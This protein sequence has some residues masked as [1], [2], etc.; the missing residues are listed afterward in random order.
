[1]LADAQQF[2]SKVRS[3]DR[4]VKSSILFNKTNVGFLLDALPIAEFAKH[5]AMESIRLVR[6]REGLN[7]GQFCNAD[8]TIDVEVTEVMRPGRRR[9]DE[10]RCGATEIIPEFDPRLGETIAIQLA[11]GIRKKSDKRYST[12]PLLLVYL[13]ITSGGRLGNEVEIAIKKLRP[14][15]ATAFREICVLWGTVWC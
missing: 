14:E 7:D 2:V 1:V 15:H 11:N 10:Y 13:N 8:E 4:L 12:K 3:F 9:G 5:R 6:Q